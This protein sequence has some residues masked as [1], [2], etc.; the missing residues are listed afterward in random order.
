MR[1]WITWGP[2]TERREVECWS[3]VKQDVP[4]KSSVGH[5]DKALLFRAQR[6]FGGRIEVIRQ[7]ITTTTTVY[8]ETPLRCS[9]CGKS[10]PLSPLWGFCDKCQKAGSGK[11]FDLPIHRTEAGYPNCSTCDAG[12]CLDC[13]DPA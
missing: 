2:Q 4:H 7:T 9:S 5:N 12:G 13:T 3:W 1:E 11:R 8:D 6:I 10:G